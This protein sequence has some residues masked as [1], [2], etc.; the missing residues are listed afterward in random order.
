VSCK[1]KSI[2]LFDKIIPVIPPIVN[3]TMNPN[4]HSIEISSDEEIPL[5]WIVD[6]HLK[7]LTPVGTAIN[8]VTLVK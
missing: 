8:I 6:N 2:L 4:T 7:I 3:N 5:P 1:T